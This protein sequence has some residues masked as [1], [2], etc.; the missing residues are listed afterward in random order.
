MSHAACRR[1]WDRLVGIAEIAEMAG[2]SR[3]VVVNWRARHDDFP[4]PV[5]KFGMGPAFDKNQIKEWLAPRIVVRT[6]SG[7]DRSSGRVQGYERE[8]EVRRVK[9]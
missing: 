3:A 1:C 5:K 8:V 7:Y 2:V 4:K 6:V 9:P